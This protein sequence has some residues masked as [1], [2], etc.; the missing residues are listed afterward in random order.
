M[1]FI[2]RLGFWVTF[3]FQVTVIENE[4]PEVTDLIS[5]DFDEHVTMHVVKLKAKD[6]FISRMGSRKSVLVSCW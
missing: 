3:D 5:S 4:K 2:D 6:T 1:D